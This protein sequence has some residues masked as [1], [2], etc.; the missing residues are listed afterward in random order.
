MRY[1]LPLLEILIDFVSEQL[2]K[3]THSAMLDTSPN[4]ESYVLV[5]S[6]AVSPDPC[7]NPTDGTT[8]GPPLSEPLSRPDW[9][10]FL[11]G[12]FPDGEKYA[13]ASALTYYIRKTI[14]HRT[15]FKCSAGIAANKV[16]I[17]GESVL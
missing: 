7:K 3:N 5:H 4:E 10:E 8:Y 9:V 1:N 14:L 13:V 15:G 12:S 11:S 17:L 16:S 6:N 2:Q